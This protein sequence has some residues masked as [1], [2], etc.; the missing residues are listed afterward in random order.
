[1]PHPLADTAAQWLF[2][3]HASRATFN[4]VQPS[5][6]QP[7]ES[8][9]YDVQDGLVARRQLVR[10]Q[11]TGG[12]KIGL[13]TPRMQA[14]CHGDRPISGV[15]FADDIRPAPAQLE[16]QRYVR[17]GLESELAVRIGR[18][19]RQPGGAVSRDD[20]AACV[21]GIAAAFELIED[22]GADY[23]TLNW[24]WLA[25]DN[26]WNAGL[27]LAAA[28]KP[29]D[30]SN[31]KGTLY[32]DGAEADTGSTRDVLGHPYD[33]VAWL[34]NHLRARGRSLEAGQWVST[35][36]IANIQFA[37]PGRHYR[38][39]IEGLPAVEVSVA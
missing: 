12:Y 24:L 34:E 27:V 1:M 20:V 28:V 17:L 33:A 13:T 19:V 3:Q 22:R 5:P 39:E 21:D 2:D 4:G 7:D 23:Q 10:P 37:R 32:I 30:V 14:L 9:A 31:L 29:R 26:S 35:G 11:Q 36:S 25:A 15:V 38:F 18:P 8:F 16:A 6:P